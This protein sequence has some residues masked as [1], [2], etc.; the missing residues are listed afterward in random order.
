GGRGELARPFQQLR[1]PDQP[2][3]ARGADELDHARP[4]LQPVDELLLSERAGESDLAQSPGESTDQPHLA[5]GLDQSDHAL[6]R[7]QSTDQPHL[8]AG[9]DDPDR[10]QPPRESTDNPQLAG[11]GDEFYRPRPSLQSTYELVIS[12]RPCELY[13]APPL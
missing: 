8:A 3:L 9:L 13:P 5:A 6:P 12:K 1:E 2:H 4:R 11:G 10:A 7:L